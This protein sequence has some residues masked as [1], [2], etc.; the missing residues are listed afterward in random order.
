[1]DLNLS[2]PLAIVGV[3][4]AAVVGL[5]ILSALLPTLFD[6]TAAIT[7]NVTTGDVGNDT[8]NTLLGV[9]GII[10]GIV[11]LVFLVAKFKK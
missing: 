6:S 8:A 7:E 2:K 4:I 3:V 9:F 10:L 11:G 5:S 1:M